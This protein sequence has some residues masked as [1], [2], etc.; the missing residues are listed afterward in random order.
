MSGYRQSA[1]GGWIAIGKDP[2]S[3]LSISIIA[4]F[5]KG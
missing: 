1:F 5:A 4:L 2:E 3:G